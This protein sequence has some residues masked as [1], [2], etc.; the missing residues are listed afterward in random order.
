LPGMCFAV[1]AGS[2]DTARRLQGLAKTIAKHFDAGE[3]S[4]PALLFQPW[5]PKLG[6]PLIWTRK[7]YCRRRM[8]QCGIALE[9][10]STSHTLATSNIW[11]TFFSYCVPEWL[12]WQSICMY[13]KRDAFGSPKRV[14]MF[15]SRHAWSAS[16]NL[17]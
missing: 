11:V 4:I 5:R 12:R 15:W 14:R 3:S 17:V 1:I 9:S 7:Y 2:W 13:V 8:I 16:N 6:F 10:C